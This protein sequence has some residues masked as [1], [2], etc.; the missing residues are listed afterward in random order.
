MSHCKLLIKG[1]RDL[2]ES[3]VKVAVKFT[4]RLSKLF[5]LTYVVAPEPIYRILFLANVPNKLSLVPS[6]LQIFRV[7]I[8]R[9]TKHIDIKSRR[10]RLNSIMRINA[11]TQSRA[12]LKGEK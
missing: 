6:S 7:T 9:H 5:L 11:R 10:A 8:F 3:S 4:A 12:A 2:Y 1:R